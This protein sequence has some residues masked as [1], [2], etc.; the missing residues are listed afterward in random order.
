MIIID[1]EKGCTHVWGRRVLRDPRPPRIMKLT[2]DGVTG[3][4]WLCGN[5]DDRISSGLYVIGEPFEK[6]DD[7]FIRRPTL[8]RAIPANDNF[9]SFLNFPISAGMSTNLRSLGAGVLC[10]AVLRQGK[11]Q[12]IMHAGT[13]RQKHI[14]VGV[15][16]RECDSG[17]FNPRP[18]ADYVP[19]DVDMEPLG[20]S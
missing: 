3:R 20:T 13:K 8:V 11:A 6:G 1:E 16:T 2:V 15:G 17:L 19:L 18:P 9:D 12:L 5:R 14:V 4:A 7:F 10:H